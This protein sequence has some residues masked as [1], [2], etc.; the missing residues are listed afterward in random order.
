MNKDRKTLRENVQA[1]VE[2]YLSKDGDCPASNLYKMILA[3][4]EKLISSTPRGGY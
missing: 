3:E 1:V 4:I 2:D